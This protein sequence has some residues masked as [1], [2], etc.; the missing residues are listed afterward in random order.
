LTEERSL[1]RRAL[2]LAG[3]A[4]GNSSG[5]RRK[6]VRPAPR[7]KPPETRLRRDRH[8]ARAAHSSEMTFVVASVAIGIGLA[9][10]TRNEPLD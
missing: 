8:N 4:C 1:P 7:R 3:R 5:M 10:G 6:F 2:H 9:C